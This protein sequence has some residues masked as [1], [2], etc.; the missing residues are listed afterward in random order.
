[1]ASRWLT[2]GAG[3]EIG[4]LHQP[5]RVPAGA[6]VRYVDRKTVPELRAHYP[7]LGAY[8]LV[9]PDILDDG[10]RLATLHDGTQDF[11]I[12]NH[13]IE[14]CEDPISALANA[15]R[16]LR[17]GGILYLAA[18]DKRRTFD[19]DRPL[20]TLAHLERDHR[21]GPS[22][23]RAG[24]FEEWARLVDHVEN[25]EERTQLLVGMDYSIHFHVWTSDSFRSFLEH[26]RATHP[27]L[28]FDVVE[29]VENDFEFIAILR[30]TSSE[31]E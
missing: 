16:V 30:K 29:F 7:E 17:D 2:G 28:S 8:E 9:E 3:I 10:E 18:P 26:C 23:S 11:V 31:E 14:H 19:Q 20:T 4:A 6:S 27:G 13:F 12:A 5:L 25:I 22:W 24:H 21:E 15:F 1:L